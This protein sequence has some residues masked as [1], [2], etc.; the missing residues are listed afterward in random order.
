MWKKFLLER[1]PT[2]DDKKPLLLIAFYPKSRVPDRHKVLQILGVFP[3]KGQPKPVNPFYN[4]T[5]L[6]HLEWLEAIVHHKFVLA[7]FGHGLDTH[8]ISEILFMGGIPVMRRST[9]SS[10]YDDSDNTVVKGGHTRG[11]LPVVIVDKWEDVTRE[12]LDEEWL[13]ISKFPAEHW[14]WSRIFINHWVDRIFA[15]K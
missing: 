7:P 9:I 8:R 5:D 1:P 11:S 15:K 3:P 6:N 12:R 2:P 10:C 14:D 13:R 4:Y